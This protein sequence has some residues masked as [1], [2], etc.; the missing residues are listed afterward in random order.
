M[1]LVSMILIQ[2]SL[3]FIKTPFIVEKHPLIAV[4]WA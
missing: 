2:L 3:L 1:H 4:N